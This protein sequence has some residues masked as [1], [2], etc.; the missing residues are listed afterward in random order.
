MTDACG[1][2]SPTNLPN[3]GSSSQASMTVTQSSSTTG[4]SGYFFGNSLVGTS[5]Y[6]TA[7]SVAIN[8]SES[9]SV[10][11]W[12]KLVTVDSFTITELQYSL[13]SG[14]QVL[15][16][17]YNNGRFTGFTNLTGN[18]IQVSDSCYYLMFQF[19]F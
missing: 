17:G 14:I 8:L 18:N 11:Y 16:I 7:S 5:M 19:L 1:G 12:L 10:F 9:F 3:T 4:A 13:R 15:S 2:I 6:L